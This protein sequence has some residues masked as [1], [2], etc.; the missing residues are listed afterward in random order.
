MFDPLNRPGA[1]IGSDT[2]FSDEENA[3]K[4][5][6][7]RVAAHAF[8]ARMD[9]DRVQSEFDATKNAYKARKRTAKS[10][11]PSGAGGPSGFDR[12]VGTA[13]TIAG[14]ASAAVGVAALV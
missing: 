2:W 3:K 11:G 8:G 9:T 1:P 7:M 5:E 6:I 10:G 14:A 13:G 12:A 4:D